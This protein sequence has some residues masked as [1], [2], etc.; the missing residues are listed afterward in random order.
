MTEG[1]PSGSTICKQRTLAS[2]HQLWEGLQIYKPALTTRVP[3]QPGE[4]T[5]MASEKLETPIFL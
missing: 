1:G 2:T 4:G 3:R 5:G